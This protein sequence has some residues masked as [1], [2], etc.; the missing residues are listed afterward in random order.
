MEVSLF[1]FCSSLIAAITGG[2][3]C[4]LLVILLAPTALMNNKRR[5]LLR[6][7]VKEQLTSRSTPAYTYSCQCLQTPY[8]WFVNSINLPSYKMPRHWTVVW[9]PLTNNTN[10]TWASFLNNHSGTRL[11][12]GLWWT[13]GWMNEGEWEWRRDYLFRLLLPGN[14]YTEEFNWRGAG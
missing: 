4:W 2:F 5:I 10:A 1:F 11:C 6:S 14:F 12:V 13:R 7:A 3:S 8:H 9:D